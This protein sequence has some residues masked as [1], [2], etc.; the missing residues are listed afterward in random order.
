MNRVQVLL[1][2][3][4]TWHMDRTAKAFAEREALAG[5]WMANK[6]STGVPSEKYRRCWPFHLA[7]KPFYAAMPKRYWEN[8]FYAFVPIWSRWVRSQTLPRCNVVQAIMGFGTEIFDR[9]DETGALKVMECPNSHPTSYFG[10]WQRECD[11][12]CPGEKVI[13]PRWMY[14][15]MNRELERADLIVVESK[16]GRESMIYNGIPDRKVVINP[17]GLDTSVFR[18]RSALPDKPRFICVGSITLR[19]GH[20]YL[21]R[22]FQIVKKALPEAELICAGGYKYDFRRER[23]KWEGT[24]THTHLPQAQLAEVLCNCT[25]FVFPSQEEGIAES[26]VQALASGLPGDRHAHWRDDDAGG[27]RGGRGYCQWPRPPA[28]CRRDDQAGD[29][30]RVESTDGRSGLSQGSH[31]QHVA[32]LRG[33]AAGRIRAPPRRARLNGLPSSLIFGNCNSQPG[34]LCAM[35]LSSMSQHTAEP[36]TPQ[37]SHSTRRVI[38]RNFLSVN[39]AVFAQR[40]LGMFTSIYT[41]RV[42]GV[43]AIGQI[44]WCTWIMSYFSLVIN[45]GWTPLPDGMLL[46]SRRRRVATSR[47]CGSCKSRWR[48]WHSLS[49]GFLLG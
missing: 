20:Q 6:N 34:N 3:T 48:W 40:F 17:L 9:A 37:A 1:V 2:S 47:T 31:S 26:Q 35:K 7:M 33:P 19:K 46:A 16:F 15:R 11:I 25:A 10:F 38:A 22:A 43:V 27:R 23:P 36:A 32:G 5:L 13:V 14:A 41:R 39:A 49:Q 29:R 30:S 4:G 44:S 18:K 45:W 21:F 24:F 28:D 8:A 42:L 12:W